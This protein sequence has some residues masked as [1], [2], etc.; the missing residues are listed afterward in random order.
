MIA[1]QSCVLCYRHIQFSNTND[2][3]FRVQIQNTIHRTYKNQIIELFFGSTVKSNAV[4][5]NKENVR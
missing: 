4:K 3:K 1:F 2:F 5:E